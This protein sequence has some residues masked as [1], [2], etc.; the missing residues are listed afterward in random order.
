MGHPVLDKARVDHQLV[1]LGLELCQGR[2]AGLHLELQL[3]DAAPE[4]GDAGGALG[5]SRLCLFE[6]GL[7][8]LDRL[9]GRLAPVD[10]LRHLAHVGLGL[11]CLGILEPVSGGALRDFDPA[12]NS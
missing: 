3:G 7:E 1:L 10:L 9:L 8:P 5:P 11:G 4:L 2:V 12:T 6:L